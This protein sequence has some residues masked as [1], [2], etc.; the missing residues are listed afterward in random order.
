ME[1]GILAVLLEADPTEPAVQVV[2]KSPVLD[3]G[4]APRPKGH[5]S[6]RADLG[7]EIHSSDR[8]NARDTDG[9]TRSL[10][11]GGCGFVAAPIAAA[12][13]WPTCVW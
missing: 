7:H 2:S 9:L 3:R 13:A 1:P 4:I 6:P 12:A 8:A 5:P 10:Q 11:N